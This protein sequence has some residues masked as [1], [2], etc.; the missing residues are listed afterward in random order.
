MKRS[1]KN[2]WTDENLGGG[3]VSPLADWVLSRLAPKKGTKKR[4]V[5]IDD[6]DDNCHGHGCYRA[7]CCTGYNDFKGKG[8]NRNRKGQ[9]PPKNRSFF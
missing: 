9:V 8:H 6:E 1:N 3:Y 5:V 7:N 2:S 4:P